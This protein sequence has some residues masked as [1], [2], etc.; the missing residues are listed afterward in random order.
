MQALFIMC[1][2]LLACGNTDSDTTED[3]VNLK[4]VGTSYNIVIGNVNPA[5]TAVT[6]VRWVGDPKLTYDLVLSNDENYIKVPLTDKSIHESNNIRALAISEKEIF[7]CLTKMQLDKKTSISLLLTVS[8]TEQNKKVTAN[9]NISP[10]YPILAKNMQ[11]RDPFITVDREHNCY[12]LITPRWKDERGGL[13]AYKSEDLESWKELGY[14]FNAEKDYL[15]TNDYWAPDTYEYEGNYYTFITVSNPTRGILRGTTI[16]KSTNGPTGP[17]HPVLPADRLNMTPE[18]MKCLDG[19]LFV[20]DS[21]TPWMIFSVEWDGPNVTDKVGEVWSQKLKKDL[22]DTDGE[23][24]LLFKASEAS[25]IQRYIGGLITDAPFIWK[26]KASG[27]LILTWS[28]F[29]PLYSIGQ[30]ISTSGNV[31]GPWTHEPVPIFSN[32]GG[33]QMIFED[34][35]GNLKISFHSPNEAVGSVRPTLTIM[36]IKIKDGK[37]EVINP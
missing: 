13:I 14:V 19:S 7:D 15:G 26:D 10:N 25:W 5:D 17:Y 8:D 3:K 34:L 35:N 12:Y 11:M 4:M 30:A 32:D 16:L 33:H 31:L 37:F 6:T 21:G 27:N 20:D 24:H 36:D 2:F 28:S 1:F 22:S 23:A 18:S 9:I 29:S